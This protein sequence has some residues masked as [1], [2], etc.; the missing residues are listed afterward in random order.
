MRRIVCSRTSAA[1]TSARR[2]GIAVSGR[3][4]L[5]AQHAGAEA[6]FLQRDLGFGQPLGHLELLLE[7]APALL[8]L[9]DRQR[10]GSTW[11]KE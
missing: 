2:P 5:G 7:E 8:G 3:L 10:V 1:V 6:A 11:S 9:A 4:G